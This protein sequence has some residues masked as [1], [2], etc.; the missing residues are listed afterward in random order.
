MKVPDNSPE[1]LRRFVY[2]ELQT[3]YTAAEIRIILDEMYAAF[4]P[5]QSP[6]ARLSESQLLLFFNGIKKLRKGMP[7][8]YVTG[9]VHFYGLDLYVN[10]HTL[11]PR[12]ETEE[13][14]DRILKNHAAT[15]LSITDACTGSGC[16]SLALQSRRPNWKVRGF[17]LF[18]ETLALAQKNALKTGL[19]VSFFR[20]DALDPDTYTH[21]QTTDILVSNPPY[22]SAGEKTDMHPNVLGF[23]P[24]SAL[25]PEGTDPLIFYRRLAQGAMQC[26]QEGGFF[27]AEINQHLP[28]ETCRVLEDAGLCEVEAHKDMSGN[29]RFVSARRA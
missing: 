28:A 9:R 24:H 12:P 8:Q 11:I 10:A 13:L 2:A 14:A 5:A 1:S 19:P 7:Y 21:L 23:E 29:W 16:I 18:S 27:Y 6:G 15:V 17:D 3:L 4:C 20:A 25:F 22:I 26:L